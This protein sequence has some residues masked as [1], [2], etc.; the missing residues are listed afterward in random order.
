MN[1]KNCGSFRV[2]QPMSSFFFFFSFSLVVVG[3]VVVCLLR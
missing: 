2:T 3:G 1:E